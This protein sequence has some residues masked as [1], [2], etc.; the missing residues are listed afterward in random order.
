[1]HN[2][3]RDI[4]YAVRQMRR[5]PGF[6]LTAVLT[7]ALGIGASSA[8]FCLLDS[9]SLH[10][11]PV[12]HGRELVRLFT[13]TP[14]HS[15]GLFTYPEY[16]QIAQR[17]KALKSVVALGR[18][19]SIMPRADGTTA[20]LLTNVVSDN[21]FEALG[22]KPILGRTFTP[23]DALTVRT[24]PAVLLSYGLW[25][26][27]FAGDPNIV[28]HQIILQRGKDRRESV[29]VWGVLP[30][31]FREI[32][33]GMDR[34]L[35]M[36]AETWAALV[37]EDELTS[38]RFAWFNLLGRLA[39]AASVAQVNDQVSVMAKG[40][41]LA[42]PTTK[43]DQGARAVSDFR[44]RVENAGTAGLVLFAVVV[45]V[46]L[47]ATLNVAHLLI[48]RALSR[49][50]EVALR[51]ALGARPRAVARQLLVENFL[52]CLLSLTSGLGIAAGIAVFLPRLLVSEPA[53]LQQV[54][55][56]ASG[57]QIDWRVFVFAS[58]MASATMLLL[59]LIP[60]RQVSRPQLMPSVQAGASARTED[61]APMAR[62]AAIW[63]QIAIS[64]ALLVSTGVLVH[65]YINTQTKSIGLTRD[66]VLLAW[67]QEPEPP[68]RDAI[69]AR[70]KAMPG[71][72]DVAYA[73]R[74][75]LSLSEGGIAVHALL[76]GHPEVRLPV[77]IKF[78]AVSPHFLNLMGT[79]IVRGRGFN[80]TDTENAPAVIIVN[81]AMARKYWPN[82][83]PIG[84]VIKLTDWRQG[85]GE[86]RIVGV[87]ESAPINSIGE[88]PEPYVYVPFDQYLVHLSNM[89]EITFAL[90]TQLNAMSLAQPARQVLIHTNPLLDPMMVTSLPELIRYSAGEY[91]MMAE[92]VSALGFIGLVLTIVGLYG[93]LAFRV[94]QRRREIG[95]RMALGASREATSLLVMRDIAGLGL[96]GLA[97]GVLLAIGASRLESSLVFGVSPFDAL[98][99]AGALLILVPAIMAAGFL[100][101]RRA[102]SIEPM[103][104][105][106]TE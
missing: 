19:G 2:L 69:V 68:I 106:R 76:P 50:P 83:N 10:P 49:A 34:D 30:A 6:T 92:L 51:I 24:H 78:N 23:A 40:W 99:M 80:E 39:P 96:I 43:H 70:M 89:G 52:V 32:D 102:A 65:S 35:W 9:Y 75:P 27:E 79:R 42:D 58:V 67:T 97:F 81:Q 28:G 84:Q 41:A 20:L 101:A 31:S 57:F 90:R 60:M 85:T 36:P 12:P 86:A 62:R 100:P 87:A 26:R 98:S 44:Y 88:F 104:A 7:L 16:Q 18:R 105:L 63:L 5:G 94:T 15:T 61:R 71:V 38:T 17:A 74:S 53:M 8:I 22:V 29:D 25:K 82:Q 64:F 91:Q 72:T 14:Q 4:R 55:A 103:Q 47:L 77:E 54:G 1:M 37:G 95:I 13:T 11:M 73:I 48:A 33:N 21:F 3:V 59:A 45:G 46:V 93:F 56:A 66:Q